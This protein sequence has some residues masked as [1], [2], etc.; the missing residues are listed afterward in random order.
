MHKGTNDFGTRLYIIEKFEVKYKLDFYKTLSVGSGSSLL[1][2]S[3]PA[4]IDFAII[5]SAINKWMDGLGSKFV[6]TFI[7]CYI[8]TGVFVMNNV[9]EVIQVISI[10]LLVAGFLLNTRRFPKSI[11][12]CNECLFILKD[13]AG[14]GDEK[15]TTSFYKRIYF[16]YWK[17]CR[18]IS[19]NTNAIEYGEKIVQIYCESGERL[20]ECMLSIDLAEVYCHQS[21]YARAKE[22]SEE[23]LSIS[24][25]I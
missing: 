14:I 8:M 21:K 1:K 11:E 16:I 2:L 5:T 25:E 22:L 20:E 7:L 17:A 15:L 6:S 4:H 19:D 12:L 13:T 18:L 10:G 23:A 3:Q 9:D 24:K